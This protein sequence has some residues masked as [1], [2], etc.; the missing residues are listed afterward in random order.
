MRIGEQSAP[1][2]S[3]TV[4]GLEL[5]DSYFKKQLAASSA[6]N[7]RIVRG[8]LAFGLSRRTLNFGLMNDPIGSV[9]PVY[10]VFHTDASQVM[11]ENMDILRPGAREGQ[12]IDRDRLLR[13]LVPVPPLVVQRALWDQVSG[14]L[15]SA[16]QEDLVS[17]AVG[18]V[19]DGLLPGLV[20]GSIELPEDASKTRAPAR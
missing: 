1:E 6:M 9:S 3:A 11:S 18:A 19:R 12:P 10:E 15:R 20:S 7:R 13:K 14:L 16:D 2:Y 5:R 17:Q 8:D 4:R